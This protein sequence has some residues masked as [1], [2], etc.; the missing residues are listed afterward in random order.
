[1]LTKCLEALGEPIIEPDQPIDGFVEK[2]ARDLAGKQ[3]N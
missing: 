2:L 1:M 3:T